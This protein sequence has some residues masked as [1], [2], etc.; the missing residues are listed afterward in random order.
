LPIKAQQLLLAAGQTAGFARLQLGE[1]R[2]GFPDPRQGPVPPSV[3]TVLGRDQKIVLH[4]VFGKHLP[5]LGH[6]GEA[7]PGP[8][9]RRRMGDVAAGEED[10]AAFGRHDPSKRLH[11]RAL[12]RAVAPQQ[13]Q[14]AFFL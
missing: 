3:G 6:I 11:G 7:E 4:T 8:R 9:M 5:V 1:Q 12:A 14:C 13:R 10:A 2:E